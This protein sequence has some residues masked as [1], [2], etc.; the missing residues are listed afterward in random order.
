MKSLRWHAECGTGHTS[1]R[2]CAKASLGNDERAG[3]MVREGSNGA[4]RQESFA[5]M[6]RTP[7]QIIC[8]YSMHL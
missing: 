1:T 7:L 3:M 2:K 4:G 5:H 6:S 8:I